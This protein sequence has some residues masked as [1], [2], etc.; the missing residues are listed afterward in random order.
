MKTPF[1]GFD[2]KYTD[3][4]MKNQLYL[5]FKSDICYYNA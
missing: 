3:L 5:Y 4:Y 1:L 2:K